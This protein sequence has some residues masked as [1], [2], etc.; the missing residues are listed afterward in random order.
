MGSQ[1]SPEDARSA[2]VPWRTNA[3]LLEEDE[4]AAVRDQVALD[5]REHV[6][7]AGGDLGVDRLG[8]EAVLG[9]LLLKDLEARR[10]EAEVVNAH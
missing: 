6:R 9:Q 3:V 7:L 2:R 5:A 10:L 4:L 1:G 8:D